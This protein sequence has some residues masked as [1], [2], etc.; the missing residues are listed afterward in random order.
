MTDGR[1]RRESELRSEVAINC[2]A[3]PLHFQSANL[4]ALLERYLQE[5]I[6]RA[7]TVPR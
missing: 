1:V 7:R 4:H 6:K 3:R 5:R 2:R